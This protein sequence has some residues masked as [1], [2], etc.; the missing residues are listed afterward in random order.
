M[1]KDLDIVVYGATGFTGKLCVKYL[2]EKAKDLNWAIA[3]RDKTKLSQVAIR[4]YPKI[5]RLVADG[6]DEEALDLITKRT[7]VIISTAGPF[8]RYG[9]KLVASCIKNSTHYVDITGETFWIKEMI[10]KHHSEA[11]TNGV[12]IIPSCGYDSLP[13]DLGVFFAAKTLQKPI[14]RI[15]SFHTG[16]GG[17][18]GGT[19][20]TGFSMGDLNLGKQMQDP[21]LL[22]PEDSVTPE[23]RSLSSD[24]VKIKKNNLIN[25]W[26]GRFIMATM[27]T[28]VVRRSAAL[29]EARQETYGVDFTYQEH[30]FY[31]KYLNAF[32]VS[33]G[34]I[35]SMIIIATP[36]RKFVRRFLPK[37][38][39]GPSEETM[40][41]GFFDCLYTV[42]AEDGSISIFR[43]HGKGDPGYRVT[44][45]FVCESALTLI[46]C[47]D[48]LP[49]GKD[50]G[51]LLTPASGL[52]QPLIE[53]LSKAGIFFEGPL[54]KSD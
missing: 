7:K 54:D 1:S 36:L 44:S 11:V 52:G 12:R 9:S 2:T 10:D 45:K 35:F 28:R 26:T 32:L 49:G 19:I 38:G 20:E 34:T 37:P 53:R 3:G 15:E 18:S 21:F 43:M 8:H 25:A 50:Y 13:S 24:K 40:R 51:G 41:K 23:Q 33:F 29:L 4:Y 48:D 14:K 27:N 22:N 17:A 16:Q 42:E 47:E 46:H 39:E 6:D 31:Q 5:E 30:A